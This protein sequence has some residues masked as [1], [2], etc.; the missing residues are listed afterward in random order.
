MSD[1]KG[2][3]GITDMVGSY[4]SPVFGN[5]L[6]DHG[7]SHY[8][9][10]TLKSM[11]SEREVTVMALSTTTKKLLLSIK[12]HRFLFFLFLLASFLKGSISVRV[13]VVVSAC[14][15][16]TYSLSMGGTHVEPQTVCV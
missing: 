3:R 12:R 15:I 11:K 2:P 7:V 4:C 6:E 9:W 13:S 5:S 10:N 1:I 14:R 16:Q 8:M